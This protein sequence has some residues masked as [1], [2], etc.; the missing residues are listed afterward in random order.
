M[1]ARRCATLTDT[2]SKSPLSLPID[3]VFT[4]DSINRIL[5]TI[6]KELALE[7]KPG[8]DPDRHVTLELEQ[9]HKNGSVLWIETTVKGLR[10]ETGRLVSVVGVSRDITE[11]KRA[12]GRHSPK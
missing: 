12:G 6:E 7:G 11:R 1:P 8:V 10:D 5:E 2:Q 4:P 3:K 9:Y